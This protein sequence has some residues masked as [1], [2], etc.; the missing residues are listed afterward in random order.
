[1]VRERKPAR[2]VGGSYISTL[3]CMSGRLARPTKY[4]APVS[5]EGWSVDEQADGVAGSAAATAS[6]DMGPKP[7][8]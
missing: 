1:M 7:P 5:W 4:A 8:R 6:V 3:A 2:G